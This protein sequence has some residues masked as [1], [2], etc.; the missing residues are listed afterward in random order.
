M[1][2]TILVNVSTGN[3]GSR[4][5]TQLSALTTRNAKVRAAVTSKNRA[6]EIKGIDVQLVEMNFNNLD[7]IKAAFEGVQKVFLLTP[8]VS[9]MEEI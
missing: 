6:S 2:D 4:L 8:L 7:T 3:V 9:N 5:V 1:A